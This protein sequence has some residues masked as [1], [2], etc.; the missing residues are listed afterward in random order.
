R[1]QRLDHRAQLVLPRVVRLAGRLHPGQ[2]VVDDPEEQ[3]VLVLEVPVE[4]HRRD[5]QLL[6]EPA[7]RD[8]VQ[9]FGVGELQRVL[10]DG[11]PGQAIR[12]HLTTIQRTVSPI[13]GTCTTYKYLVQVPRTGT[14][15]SVCG[16]N[17]NGEQATVGRPGRGGARD[18]GGLPRQQRRERG[19]AL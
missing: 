10:G 6:R 8:A 15:Y 17:S 5:A 2:R 13:R 7:D 12:T 19:A 9:P 11:G 14:P 1:E 3:L 4:R 18:P 16:G